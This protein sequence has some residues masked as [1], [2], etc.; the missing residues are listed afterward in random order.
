MGLAFAAL[1]DL[2]PANG[3]KAADLR[4]AR[5]WLQKSLHAWERDSIQGAS[6]PVA[7]YES[8]RVR[9]ELANCESTLAK[10]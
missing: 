7:G 6:D 1:A 9:R 3:K 4:E 5:S 10:I 2:A 8:N